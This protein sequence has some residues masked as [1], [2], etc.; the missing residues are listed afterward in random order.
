MMPSDRRGA[1]TVETAL[2]LPILL[3]VVFSAVDFARLNML[4]NTAEDACYEGARKGIVPGATAQSVMTT[5]A[6][7][8]KTVGAANASVSISPAV[9][10]NTIS[11]VTVTV[12]IPLKDNAWTAAAARTDKVL[13]KSCTLSCERSGT[14]LAANLSNGTNGGDSSILTMTVASLTG[15][16]GNTISAA[17]QAAQSQGS[18]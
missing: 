8:L 18:W 1:V 10:D 3:L 4:R 2:A 13:T 17:Q 6:Q 16:L 11:S 5:T 9:L 15:L 7:I 12:T 14:N